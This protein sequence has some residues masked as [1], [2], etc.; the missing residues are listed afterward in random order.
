MQIFCGD[1]VWKQALGD[2]RK[3]F[4]KIQDIFTPSAYATFTEPERT[5][6]ELFLKEAFTFCK[7]I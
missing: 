3:H 6:L 1:M 4:F 2:S 5:A 7:M